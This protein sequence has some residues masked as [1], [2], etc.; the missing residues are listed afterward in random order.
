M[1][2]W[3]TQLTLFCFPYSE[4]L[5]MRIISV[6]FGNFLRL[7]AQATTNGK[8]LTIK[9]LKFQ[10]QAFLDQLKSALPQLLW[11]THLIKETII[12]SKLKSQL[13]PLLPGL[14][15]MLKW[16]KM[17]RRLFSILSLWTNMEGNSLIVHQL[18]WVLNLRVLGLFL[19]FLHQR[20]M[21]MFR[22]M[23]PKTNT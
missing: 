20:G 21:N 14:K 11:E 18:N 4:A 10:V 13:S 16:R 19:V 12:Q 17:L 23:F 15:I 9:L 22:I 8:F 3:I 2:K 7:A 1:S 5:L 6:S